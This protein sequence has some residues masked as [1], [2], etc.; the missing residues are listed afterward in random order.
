[1]LFSKFQAITSMESRLFLTVFIGDYAA[2][3]TQTCCTNTLLLVLITQKL[4]KTMKYK[5][6]NTKFVTLL[7]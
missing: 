3:I 5:P 6:K 7:C 1:M 4:R 2:A